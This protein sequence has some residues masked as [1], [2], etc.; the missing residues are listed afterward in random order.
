[1][2]L[3]ETPA[4]LNAKCSTVAMRVAEEFSSWL[5]VRQVVSGFT[6]L[7]P[8]S[9]D[10]VRQFNLP[11]SSKAGMVTAPIN[12]LLQHC[13]EPA[14]AET[15]ASAPTEGK[16]A[17]DE[18]GAAEL[19]EDT[20]MAEASAAEAAEPLTEASTR[21]GE[22]DA[23]APEAG[24]STVDAEQL[25]S[26]ANGTGSA[27]NGTAGAGKV[28]QAEYQSR[29]THATSGSNRE[30]PEA[31]QQACR[32]GFGCCILAAPYVQPLALLRKV[33]PL[34]APSGAF[35]IFANCLQPLAECMLA[36]Q[37]SPCLPASCAVFVSDRSPAS[38]PLLKYCLLIWWSAVGLMHATKRRL[39]LLCRFQ[40]K[41]WRCSC[42][43]RGGGSTR[44]C[45]AGLIQR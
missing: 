34:L 12:A 26:A 7:K 35:A 23:A 43:S 30:L 21:A 42:K 15:P 17:A 33:L 4:T 1:M 24:T 45:Q 13:C 20:A 41:Q 19:K 38:C 6:G 2:Y 16:A 40:R 8:P 3:T 36:L 11:A 28:A 18:T 27:A 39:Y 9:L 10:I 5:S 14:T 32:Q 37:V 25:G 31:V 29:I 22:A 44:C